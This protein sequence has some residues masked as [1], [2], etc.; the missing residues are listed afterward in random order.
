M[1]SMYHRPLLLLSALLLANGCST[2]TSTGSDRPAR[3]LASSLTFHASFDTSTDADLARGDRRLHVAPQWGHPRTVTPGLPPGNTV[4]LAPGQGKYGGAL[5]FEKTIKEL[6]CYQAAGNVPYQT[7]GWSGTVSMWLRLH[8]EEDLAPGYCDTVQI[9]SKDWNDAAFFTD[10]SKDEKP[11][12]FRLGAFSDL[13]FW[14][15]TNTP[16][17]S[18]P[19]KLRPMVTVKNPPFGRDRWTHVVFTWE[20]FNSGRPSGRA[21]FYMD[22]IFRGEVAARE[23]RWTWDLSRCLIMLGLSYTG[24][25]DDV[26]IFD[27]ALTDAEVVMLRDLP[28][29]VTGLRAPGH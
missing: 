4:H 11:R 8:P 3:R 27:R 7:N 24:W 21:R 6:V 9:T 14:N 18:V 13:K 12:D 10:F 20:D 28:H 25:M 5:R 1:I 19:E 29:G 17:E 16:W 15:P 2:S 23:Q 26:A 22:G